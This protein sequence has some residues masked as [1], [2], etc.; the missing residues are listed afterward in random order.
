MERA[1][2]PWGISRDKRMDWAGS[3]QVPTIEEVPDPDVLYWVGCAA[4]YDAGAQKTSR[5]VVEL[6]TEGNVKFAVL[7]KRE[8]CTGDSARR[9]GNELLYQELAQTAIATLKEAAPKLVIASCPHCVNTI[10]TEYPQ[11][12]GNFNVMHHSEYLD[13]MVREGKLKPSPSGATVTFHDPCYLGRHR[14]TYEEPRSL[15][16]ILSNDYVELDRTKSN[17]F[18]CG[19]G[20]AQFWKEEE[21][22][23]E[24][25]SD[26]RFRE[27]QH[28]L[29]GAAKVDS[30][31]SEKVLAVGC[32]FCK[33]MLQ[34]SPSA[35]EDP[36]IVI[37]DV[38]ELLLEGVRRGK[39]LSPAAPSLAALPLVPSSSP[40]PSPAPPIVA[41]LSEA[42]PSTVADARPTEG[43]GGFSPRPDQLA[44]LSAS[45]PDAHA[46]DPTPPSSQWNVPAP[47]PPERK[48]WTPKAT[49]PP[50]AQPEQSAPPEPTQTPSPPIRKKWQPGNK[51]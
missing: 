32:P 49:P 42:L 40:V 26:N 15:L 10:A 38:A 20:G 39:G 51:N 3:L 36:S 16:K 24:R 13:L 17:S 34:S 5:A 30:T 41:A 6:L 18:C 25:I 12:G 47:N 37:K 27:A 29:D 19:A 45:A 46:S 50:P 14:G 11:F 4:S 35:G 48:K 31:S 7:G 9:A 28:T 21:K 2:N 43:G 23:T 1:A 8:S 33:S 44:S 22:G